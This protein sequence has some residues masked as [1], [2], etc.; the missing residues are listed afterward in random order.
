MPVLEFLIEWS[1]AGREHV[2]R[3]G[4]GGRWSRSGGGRT[5]VGG[6]EGVVEVEVEGWSGG[7]RSMVEVGPK[8]VGGSR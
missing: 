8:L 2:F 5:K 1:A 4:V 7:G 6:L 3:V